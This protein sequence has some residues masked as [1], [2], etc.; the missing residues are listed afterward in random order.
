MLGGETTPGWM[1]IYLF[2]SLGC[3]GI[4]WD[5]FWDVLGL[6]VFI[7]GHSK[8]TTIFRCYRFSSQERLKQLLDKLHMK[9]SE[10]VP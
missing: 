9:E 4:F 6:C 7:F 3:F 8:K 2:K 10:L 5:V 1:G